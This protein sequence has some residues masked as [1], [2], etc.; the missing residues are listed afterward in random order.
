MIAFPPCKINLGLHVVRRRDDG[1]H[2]IETC[3]YPLPFTDVLEIVPANDFLFQQTGL[4]LPGTEHENLCVKAYQLLKD[5]YNLPAF[6]IYLHKL[7][8]PGAGLGGGSS[9]AAW[10]LRLLHILFS[11]SV[12]YEELTAI[13]SILGS[14]CP[15][16]MYDGPMIGSGRGEILQPAEVSLKGHYLILL[17]PDIHVS[18]TEAYSLIKPGEPASSL[19]DILKNKPETW[20]SGLI[21]DFE[22][23][24]SERYPII[25]ELKNALYRS[26][27]IFA[28]MTGSGSA[29]YGIFGTKTEIPKSIRH[30]VIW[31]GDL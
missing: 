28:S 24:V 9:D 27:A 22:K 17:K 14:D 20:K 7:I 3:F 29:V 6:A 31:E 26:G 12:S 13:A 5:K 30:Y 19:K 16:F 15:F 4:T 1:Y 18:T 8:P 25:G 2:D 11:P 23:P 10:T 21:N